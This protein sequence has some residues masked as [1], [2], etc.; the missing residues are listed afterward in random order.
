MNLPVELA[1]MI[2]KGVPHT[3]IQVFAGLPG[4]AGCFFRNLTY[5]FSRL[6]V[7]TLSITIRHG[8]Y[9]SRVNDLLVGS[10]HYS[11]K[12]HHRKLKIFVRDS[13]TENS[14][15][16]EFKLIELI[17]LLAQYTVFL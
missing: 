16:E 17:A 9:A 6:R 8:N 15:A 7:S 5:T 13:I 10:I 4:V 12:A 3:L 1:G 2:L 14:T 11:F